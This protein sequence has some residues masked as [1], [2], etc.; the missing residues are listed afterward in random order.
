[1]ASDDF[2]EPREL[3]SD[4]PDLSLRPPQ[5][6]SPAEQ[7]RIAKIYPPVNEEETT[8]QSSFRFPIRSLL[9]F[10]AAVAVGLGGSNF[11]SAKMF[12]GLLAIAANLVVFG[13]E[14]KQVDEPWMRSV[15]I[16][17]CVACGV[18]IFMALFG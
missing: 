7:E 12:A 13:M 10:A 8:P 16:W 5:G 6:R 4:D 15:M 9:M 18:A 11:I 14:F 17:L 1:M 2:Q 3:E